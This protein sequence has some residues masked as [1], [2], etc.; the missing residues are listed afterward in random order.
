MTH[1]LLLLNQNGTNNKR[2]TQAHQMKQF[3]Y[4][5]VA[6]RTHIISLTLIQFLVIGQKS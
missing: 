5:K 6:E 3:V 1:T 2:D 4:T